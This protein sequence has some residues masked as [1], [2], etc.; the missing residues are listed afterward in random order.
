[1]ESN[2]LG[3]A[4]CCAL[5]LVIAE[6]E[7]ATA[8]DGGTVPARP[9]VACRALLVRLRPPLL[10]LL[11]LLMRPLVGSRWILVLLPSLSLSSSGWCPVR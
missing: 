10:A 8:V 11:P 7:D 1:M 5:E 4:R 3:A 2:A 9:D 6:V